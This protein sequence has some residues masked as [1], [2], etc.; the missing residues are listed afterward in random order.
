MNDEL[1]EF[2][3]R[4]ALLEGRKAREKCGD[5]PPVG[6]VFVCDSKIVARGHTNEPGKPH[7][8]A[9]ALGQLALNVKGVVGFVTL[10][11]C[12]FY[13]RTPSCAQ[14]L[15]DYGI[16]ELFVG[17][18]D[19]D[20]R[21]SGAGLDILKNAG[22]KVETGLLEKEILMDIGARLNFRRH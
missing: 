3:M 21:N 22:V 13:G 6:C 20:P 9:M 14:A 12:S 18:L 15:V 5:N 10:E 2:F 8:E 1:S 4:Q 16:S 17:I 7:A 11:P 19:P